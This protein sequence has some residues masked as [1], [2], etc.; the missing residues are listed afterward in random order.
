MSDTVVVPAAEATAITEPVAPATVGGEHPAAGGGGVGGRNPNPAQPAQIT[1]E[2]QASVLKNLFGDEWDNPEAIKEKLA[3]KAPDPEPTPFELQQKEIEK[4]KKVLDKFLQLDKTDTEKYS[5]EDYSQFKQF[6][7]SD[8]VKVGREAMI[9]EIMGSKPGMTAERAEVIFNK[10]QSIYSDSEL[11]LMDEADQ[12]AVKEA[13]ETAEKSLKIRGENIISQY[14]TEFQNLQ[15]AV[16][17]EEIGQ[18]E[19]KNYSVQAAEFI[20]KYPK[21]FPVKI[22]ELVAGQPIPDITLEVSP[23][24]ISEAKEFFSDMA[25]VQQF[26]FKD[27]KPNVEALFKGYLADKMQVEALQ[28]AVHATQNRVIAEGEKNF[29]P[30]PVDLG[31]NNKPNTSDKTV[32]IGKPVS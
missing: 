7:K 21:S 27:G 4:D 29:S 24:I 19:V 8:P 10:R 23:T 13:R 11:E 15:K 12:E 28:K 1:P 17:D 2:L 25:K 18:N 26:Y 30:N 31:P 6:L 5:V 16:E 14:K 20:D 3:Y 22:P 9:A 32:K